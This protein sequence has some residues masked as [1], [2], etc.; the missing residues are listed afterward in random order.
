VSPCRDGISGIKN[1][2]DLI[3][4]ISPGTENAEMYSSISHILIFNKVRTA[5]TAS[6]RMWNSVASGKYRISLYCIPPRKEL[7]LILSP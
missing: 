6:I 3:T 2:F 5:T 7:V 1:F 4:N